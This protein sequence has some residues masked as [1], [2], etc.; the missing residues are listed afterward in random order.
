MQ[1]VFCSLDKLQKNAQIRL[2]CD[3]LTGSIPAAQ[4]HYIMTI[5]ALVHGLAPA[6]SLGLDDVSN[7]LQTIYPDA[8]EEHLHE[9]SH[10]FRDSSHVRLGFT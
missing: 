3:V 7:L 4:W 9:L 1:Q 2:Y 5:S 8:R 10:R 6:P